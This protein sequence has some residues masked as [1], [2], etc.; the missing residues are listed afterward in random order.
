MNTDI[1]NFLKTLPE[2]ELKASKQLINK[3]QKN[4]FIIFKVRDSYVI[5]SLLIFLCDFFNESIKAV[6]GKT[7]DTDIVHVRQIF[8]Y[9]S[10]IFLSGYSLKRIGKTINI[11]YSTVL[12]SIKTI[13]NELSIKQVTALKTKIEHV[14]PAFKQYFRNYLIN[15]YYINT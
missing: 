7:Q 9:F 1:T 10:K 2:N 5:E 6:R 13:I 15:R 3:L 14:K 12:Y 8:C 11:H 4:E